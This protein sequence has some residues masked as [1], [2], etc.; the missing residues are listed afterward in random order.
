MPR[1]RV[2]LA[3]GANLPW[4][5]QDPATSFRVAQRRLS[6]LGIRILSVSPSYSN[7]AD[8]PGSGPDFLNAVVLAETTHS[9]SMTMLVLLR[10][11][12]SFGRQQLSRSG[13]RAL[14][15]D[16]IA[17]GRCSYPNSARWR[18][19]AAFETRTRTGRA[20]LILPHPAAHRRAFVLKP[21]LDVAP[22]W[23]HPSLRKS[24]VA[25]YRGLP[26]AARLGMERLA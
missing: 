8:P 15:L 25:L 19:R 3:L 13:P 7:P 4:G 21:L 20:R 23:S 6:G 2:L 5:G 24:A 18:F 9:R 12:R 26:A 11:E 14:D 1:T 16:L 10:V 22:R 17:Y